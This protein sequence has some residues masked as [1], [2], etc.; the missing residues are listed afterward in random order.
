[1]KTM[2]IYRAV[3][4]YFDHWAKKY[5]ATTEEYIPAQT[6]LEAFH[7]HMV[8]EYEISVLTRRYPPPKHH[9]ERYFYLRVDN[10]E[11][12]ALFKLKWG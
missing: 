2:Q 12:A 11:K 8:S 3:E 1:M 9:L 10:E 4:N 5:R 6:L 7:V